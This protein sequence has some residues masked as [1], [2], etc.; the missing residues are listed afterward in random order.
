MSFPKQRFT[1]YRKAKK[2]EGRCP[3]CTSVRYEW[4]GKRPRCGDF[5][6]SQAVGKTMTCDGFINKNDNNPGIN[7]R[8]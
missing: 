2:G 1:N 6:F 5:G 7:K 3:D 4:W 8:P